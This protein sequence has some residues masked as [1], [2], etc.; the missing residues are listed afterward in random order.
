MVFRDAD[1][2]EATRLVEQF[3]ISYALLPSSVRIAGRTAE[4]TICFEIRGRHGERTH[5]NRR[6]PECRQLSRALFEVGDLVQRDCREA[7][8]A[9]QK[10]VRYAP[11]SGEGG[12]ACLR[13][14]SEWKC[15]FAEAADGWALQLL[16]R[17][18]DALRTLGCAE[19]GN[20][21]G[22]VSP[23]R[24]VHSGPRWCSYADE[25]PESA[26]AS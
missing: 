3:V 4:I 19:R 17:V 6:C 15:A 22:E 2:E 26:L 20:S 8:P 21:E 16:E 7:T 12:H 1:I 9:K 18:T 25:S 23:P 13:V 24:A 5:R 10:F 14:E 11:V